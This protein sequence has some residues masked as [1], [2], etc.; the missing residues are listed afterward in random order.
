MHGAG[1]DPAGL[2]A[3]LHHLAAIERPSASEGE[4]EAAEWIA[5]RLEALNCSAQVEEERAHGTYWWPLGIAAAAGAVGGALASWGRRH[6]SA[7]RVSE[8]PRGGGGGRRACSLRLAGGALAAAGAAAIAD[9][10]TG[11]R[12]WLRRALLPHR[13]T[14]NV[15]AQA[16]DRDASR[17]LVL[18]AHHDAAHTS[19]L[20]DPRPLRAF[21]DRFPDVYARCTSTPPLMWP[22]IGGPALAA[23]GALTGSRALLRAGTLVS[24]ETVA[25]MAEIGAGAVVPGANDNLTG[26]AT[27]LG[28]A[29][30]LREEPVEGLR[31]LLLSTGSEESFM[32]GMQAFAVRHFPSLPV[33]TTHIICVDTVGS[34]R[35]VLIEGEGMLRM[36]LYPEDFKALV[37]GCADREG[38]PLDGGVTFRNATDALIALKAGYPTV[39][40]GSFDR[41]RMPA[42][43]HAPTDTAENVELGTLRQAVTLCTAVVRRMASSGAGD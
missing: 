1:Q 16:G 6:G 32:E 37:R 7:T 30:A 26:V 14:F 9:D 39:M 15:V 25:A 21:A 33:E 19:M 12:L 23:L 17:T 36:N 40:L 10:I 3:A 8:R 20:F 18:V 2:E 22:V 4:R 35:L 29:H 38:I 27:L 13:P 43:Y 5:A 42:N 24:A 28:V 11:G 41:Y 34:P 31:V